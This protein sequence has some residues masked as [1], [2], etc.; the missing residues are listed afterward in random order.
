MDI[1]VSVVSFSED[2]LVSWNA[3]SWTRDEGNS[4]GRRHL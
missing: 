3:A 2:M 1:K 4:E